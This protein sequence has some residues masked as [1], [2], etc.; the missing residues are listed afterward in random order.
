MVDENKNNEKNQILLKLYQDTK[1]PNSYGS[2][3]GLLQSAKK[4]YPSIKRSDITSFK[5]CKSLYTP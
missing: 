5:D 3:Q 1:Q 2:I 4:I